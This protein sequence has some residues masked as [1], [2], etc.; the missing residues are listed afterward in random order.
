MSYNFIESY[1]II[2]VSIIQTT[3]ADVENNALEMFKKGF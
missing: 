1:K 2:L 3:T